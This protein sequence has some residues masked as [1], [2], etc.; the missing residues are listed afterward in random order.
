MDWNC[1]QLVGFGVRKGKEFLE[2]ICD[3]Q[4]LKYSL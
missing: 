1:D 3:Y 4:L 2:H